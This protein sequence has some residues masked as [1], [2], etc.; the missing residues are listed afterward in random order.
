[1]FNAELSFE[2]D[3]N[4]RSVHLFVILKDQTVRPDQNI[5]TIN[6]LELMMNL[7]IKEIVLACIWR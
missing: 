1:V 5:G 4:A 7:C 3:T 2:S 6:L